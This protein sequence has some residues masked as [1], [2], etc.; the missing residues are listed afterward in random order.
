MSAAFS[1]GGESL[2]AT[3]NDGDSTVSVFSVRRRTGELTP[4]QR[5]PLRPGRGPLG[6]IQR[7]GEAQRI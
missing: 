3:A 5:S 2:L 7:A 4:V 1:V 6:G